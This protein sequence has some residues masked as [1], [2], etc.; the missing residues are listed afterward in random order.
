MAQ[1][2]TAVQ[3]TTR[4]DFIK[5]C[6]PGKLTGCEDDFTKLVWSFNLEEHFSYKEVYDQFKKVLLARHWE[7][8]ALPLKTHWLVN[9]LCPFC[10]CT[11]HNP[12]IVL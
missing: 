1:A 7:P 9:A 4:R 11:S 12:N 10:H 6:V 5:G 8:L 2:Q 3:V